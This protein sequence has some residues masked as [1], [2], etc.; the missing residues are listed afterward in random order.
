M[1]FHF[2]IA[3]TVFWIYHHQFIIACQNKNINL[4]DVYSNVN[5]IDLL[6]IF[7]I[8]WPSLKFDSIRVHAPSGETACMGGEESL[9]PYPTGPDQWPVPGYLPRPAGQ[10]C[11][12]RWSSQGPWESCLLSGITTD[13]YQVEYILYIKHFSLYYLVSAD[14]SLF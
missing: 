9:L 8:A 6:P 2:V 7:V 14:N 12:G 1:L 10:V 4:Y 11:G 3:F 13:H 5:F